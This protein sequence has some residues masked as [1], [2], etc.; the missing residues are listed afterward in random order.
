RVHSL[1]ERFG[2]DGRRDSGL[3]DVLAEGSEPGGGRESKVAK[4]VCTSAGEP[5][6]VFVATQR[7]VVVVTAGRVNRAGLDVLGVE[8]DGPSPSTARI[9]PG[10]GRWRAEQ[11]AEPRKGPVR[12]GLL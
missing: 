9:G 8:Q 3:E 2:G 4:A 12:S 11:G 1:A 7:R 5:Q 10:G 6:Q